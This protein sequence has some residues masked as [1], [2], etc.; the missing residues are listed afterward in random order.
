M[1]SL[2]PIQTLKFKNATFAKNIKFTHSIIKMKIIN[3]IK[4]NIQ[5]IRKDLNL[6]AVWIA[7]NKQNKKRR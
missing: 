6:F 2:R 1:K 4:E 7:A 5:K 3:H